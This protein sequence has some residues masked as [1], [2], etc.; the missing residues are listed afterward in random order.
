MR[1]IPSV[2]ANGAPNC[3]ASPPDCSANEAVRKRRARGW[4]FYRVAVL[5]I[6]LVIDLCLRLPTRQSGQTEQRRHTQQEGSSVHHLISPDTLR[7]PDIRPIFP[8]CEFTLNTT[9]AFCH[10]RHYA[11]FLLAC[12]YICSTVL[13]RGTSDVGEHSLRNSLQPINLKQ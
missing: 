12:R 2:A 13:G 10:L 1:T 8:I 6:A 11:D 9:F 4:A 5:I 7:T 3:S